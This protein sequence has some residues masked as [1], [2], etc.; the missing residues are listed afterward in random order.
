MSIPR[1]LVVRCNETDVAA[2]NDGPSQPALRKTDSPLLSCTHRWRYETRIARVAV[3]HKVV[4]RWFDLQ[5][6]HCAPGTVRAHTMT[7]VRASIGTI[8]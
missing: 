2:S 8:Y 3:C 6:K 5:G 4:S 1:A 7:W